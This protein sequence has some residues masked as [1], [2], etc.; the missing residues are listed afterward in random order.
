MSPTGSGAHEDSFTGVGG[1]TI[2]WRAWLPEAPP[3]AVVTISH[4]FGEH[5]GR[6]AHVA[7][8][9]VAEGYAAYALDH[10]GHGHS[11]GVR[12]RISLADAVVDLDR[13]IG[14]EAERH[15]N[16]DLFL[17]GHS[18]GGAIALRYAMAHQD[19][20]AG[21]ILSGPLAEISGRLAVQFVGK[22][23]GRLAPGL[24]LARIDPDLISRDPEV[25]TAYVEDPLVYHQPV[26][27]GT[28]AE[29]VRHVETLPADA[30]TITLPTLIMYGT[31]DKLAATGGS[32]MLSQ[33]IASADLTI[34][35]YEGLCHEILNEPEQDAVL[36]EVCTWL[37]ARV[38]A[39]QP[40]PHAPA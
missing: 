22:L 40:A 31:G 3:R 25:V 10:H 33:R 19:R 5:S 16:R 35:P 15:P 36:D 9:L 13:L 28:V 8:R 24:P 2:F 17:L 1:R 11:E 18:M 4:G 12:A 20:L 27:A 32:V 6:Y 26:P 38:A 34:T 23:I 39:P 37:A 14:I 21:L 29:F 30:A 7:E